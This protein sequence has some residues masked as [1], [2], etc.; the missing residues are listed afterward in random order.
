MHFS[1]CS[2]SS[3]HS[4]SSAGDL[5]MRCRVLR[6]FPHVT[7]QSLHSDHGVSR[8]GI[9][10]IYNKTNS[11]GCLNV[12]NCNSKKQHKTSVISSY[13]F[14]VKEKAGQ[15]KYI[16]HCYSRQSGIMHFST[17]K[18]SAPQMEPSAGGIFTK[19]SLLFMPRPQVALHVS[20]S[21]HSVTRQ[22]LGTKVMKTTQSHVIMQENY[23]FSV[24][25]G[26]VNGQERNS[27]QSSLTTQ[28]SVSCV[29]TAH[30]EPSSGNCF[31]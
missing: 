6:P 12:K 3:A 5:N 8:H 23:A 22:L 11:V 2:T 27:Q 21:P 30:T 28:S 24:N 17:C 1:T 19:R 18:T 29:G 9:V 25:K 4:P 13:R 26:F 16:N 15:L 14:V 20:H 7:L 31:T 10:S